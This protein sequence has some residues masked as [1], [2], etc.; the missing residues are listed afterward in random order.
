MNVQFHVVDVTPS[1]EA[2]S[3]HLLLVYR[4]EQPL[5]SCV[6]ER[7]LVIKKTFHWFWYFVLFIFVCIPFIYGCG[8][9]ML[10]NV[11][12]LC[13]CWGRLC[14]YSAVSFIHVTMEQGEL[15]RDEVGI[16][17]SQIQT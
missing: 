5:G 11:L 10:E 3:E 16:R 1:I 12:N 14:S 8:K 13:V 4:L 7:V 15:D 6:H 17:D 9:V 2:A